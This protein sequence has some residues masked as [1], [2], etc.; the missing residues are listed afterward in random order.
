MKAENSLYRLCPENRS[1]QTHKRSE[2]T[3]EA[4]L[5]Q[6]QGKED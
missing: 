3:G 6:T 4:A 5:D 2:D 1:A